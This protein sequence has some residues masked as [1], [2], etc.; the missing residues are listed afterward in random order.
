MLKEAKWHWKLDFLKF[1]KWMHAF[2]DHCA[3]C[4][5]ISS[6]SLIGRSLRCFVFALF[7]FKNNGS[8]DYMIQAEI[9]NPQ[10][11]SPS[12]SIYSSLIVILK[13]EY[14]NLDIFID[15][16]SGQPLSHTGR[17]TTVLDTESHV[18]QSTWLSLD[19]GTFV[20]MHCSKTNKKKSSGVT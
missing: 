3:W 2:I 9:E 11:F 17:Q 14:W 16:Y 10:I 19:W 1:K 12:K 5:W 20:H 6:L 8:I 4:I 15:S 18:L 13:M 7:F